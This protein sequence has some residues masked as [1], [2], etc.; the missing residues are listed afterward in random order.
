MIT[1]NDLKALL[2]IAKRPDLGVSELDVVIRVEQA[3]AGAPPPEVA[4]AVW[5]RSFLRKAG[6]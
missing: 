3:L 5:T 1:Q 6:T 4:E 2:D